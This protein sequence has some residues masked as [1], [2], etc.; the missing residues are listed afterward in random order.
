MLETERLLMT[1]LT[2]EDLPWLIEMRS[3]AAVN[4]FLGGPQLQSADALAKRM[5]FYRA[6]HEKLGFGFC[7]FQLKA[8]GELI[9][10][11]GLQPLEDT[12]EIEIGYNF[13]EKY[14][15]QGFG[16]ECALAWLRYGFEMAGLSRIVAVADPE[17]KGSWRIM[18]KC[19]MRYEKTELHYGFDC[20]YYLITRDEFQVSVPGLS[21]FA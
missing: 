5:D 4:R 8:T 18:E 7:K 10:T 13:S 2:R 11:G 3:P 21:N 6:S 12:G 20:V 19:G 17:N 9:G 16:F 1:P 15:R 14:W